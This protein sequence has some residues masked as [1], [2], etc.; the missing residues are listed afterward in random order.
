MVLMD[1]QPEMSIA[2]G[3]VNEN[4]LIV[5]ITR[6]L[7]KL[8]LQNASGV[9]VI[10]R[11]MLEKLE[12][13]GVQKEKITVISN[14]ADE[15]LVFPISVNE[16]KLR[17]DMGWQKKFVV[18]YAGN[19]GLPQY[20]EDLLS[21]AEKL[22][23]NKNIQFVFI[24]EGRQKI[25][26]KEIINNKNLSNVQ[27][28]PFLHLQYSLAEIMSSADLHFVSLKEKCT[29]LAVPSKA[30]TIFASGR[31]LI[32]QGNK[33]CEIALILEEHNNG[34]TVPI[35]DVNSLQSAIEKLFENKNLR[36]SMGNKSR[37][38]ATNLLS[39]KVAIKKYV[40]FLIGSRISESG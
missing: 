28:L 11:C 13:L 10:G 32:F 22:S 38:L 36:E 2:L 40:D 9:V 26:I 25:K 18:L 14:W 20:F 35:G 24:G 6:K 31:P 5:K 34:I 3:L 8:A 30:Y 37:W 21:V 27:L 39:Q 16:N 33:K 15:Q 17:Q 12:N 29:G 4:S 7:S 23:G 19:I 1:I